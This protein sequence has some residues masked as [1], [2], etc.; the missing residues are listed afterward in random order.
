MLKISEHKL[1][2]ENANYFL[3]YCFHIRCITC[4]FSTRLQY[5]LLHCL[6]AAM[7]LKPEKLLKA[8][9]HYHIDIAQ[10][11]EYL[12]LRSYS[13]FLP[14]MPYNHYLPFSSTQTEPHPLS[15]QHQYQE[16]KD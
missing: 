14:Q 12:G 1:H 10:T 16:F 13:V 7:C 2:I 11:E 8:S 6:L 4:E 3:S 5:Y 9:L 15:L